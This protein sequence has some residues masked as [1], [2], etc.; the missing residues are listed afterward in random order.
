MS[1]LFDDV[2]RVI[3]SPVSRRKMLGMVG[4]SIGGALLAAL[5]LQSAALGQTQE[6]DPRPRCPKGT[7]PCRGKCC[8]EG[9]ICCGGICCSTRTAVCQSSFCCESGIV[10]AGKCCHVNEYCTKGECRKV[11]SPPAP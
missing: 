9:L 3:A 8:P 2:S 10:C 5:G 6:D 7:T 4:S 1:S 11:I